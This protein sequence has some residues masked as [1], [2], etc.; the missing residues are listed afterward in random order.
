MIKR[1]IRK[2]SIH[3][4]LSLN[5]NI[6]LMIYIF[7]IINI[8]LYIFQDYLSHTCWILLLKVS[9]EIFRDRATF[10]TVFKGATIPPVPRVTAEIRT[11]A[12][13]CLGRPMYYTPQP[14]RTLWSLTL[15]YRRLLLILLMETSV[16]GAVHPTQYSCLEGE[17][18]MIQTV[19][20]ITAAT[21]LL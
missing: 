6:Q 11:R 18:A 19:P 9:C 16:F 2:V 15:I 1:T 17:G 21:K 3:K 20:R 7:E 4:V 5:F 12:R 14:S 13:S 10:S 8:Y